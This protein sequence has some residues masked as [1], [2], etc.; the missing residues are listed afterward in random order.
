M[1]NYQVKL[2][3]VRFYAYHGYFPEE[4]ILGN[5]FILNLEVLVL[6]S[7][8][9]DDKLN[10]TLD[11]GTLYAICKQVMNH[12]VDLLETVLEAILEKLKHTSS[13]IKQIKLSLVK[14]NPPLGLSAGSSS[15]SLEWN[16]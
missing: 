10:Q 2:K 8:A 6:N 15:I 1:E 11:Y 4:R 7:Q 16:K 9:I 13:Q 3:D 14:E 5:W 12:P